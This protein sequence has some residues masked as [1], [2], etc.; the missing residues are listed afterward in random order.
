MSLTHEPGVAALRLLVAVADEGGLGAGA[1]AVGMAQS[2]ASRTLAGLEQRL[3]DL[4]DLRARIEALRAQ[5]R[6][7][8]D[9]RNSRPSPLLVLEVLSRLLPDTV[10]LTETRL[11]GNE[12][13]ISGLA[14]EASTLVPLVEARR[15]WLARL[16][17]A[18]RRR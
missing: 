13:F 1:R 7:F 3:S 8:A 2:N 10:W 4:P 16:L 12:L 5:A 14:E 18:V 6:F 9:D 15:P 17:E 11:D